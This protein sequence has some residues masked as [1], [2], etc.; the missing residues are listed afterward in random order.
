MNLD[1]ILYVLG[2]VWAFSIVGY[3]IKKAFDALWKK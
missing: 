3:G 2:L 1:D